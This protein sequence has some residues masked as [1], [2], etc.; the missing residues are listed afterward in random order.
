[1]EPVRLP[2]P[3][4]NELLH[5]AQ[6]SPEQE[7]CGLISGRDGAFHKCYPIANVAGDRKHLFALAPKGQ[8]DAMRR[9][10]AAGEE[11]VAIY[12]SHPDA[13]PLPSPADIQQSEY[14]NVL[15]LIISLNTEGV[16]ELRGFRIRGQKVEE[17]AIGI[18]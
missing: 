6:R 17:V 15:Y 10:R 12:H 16:L 9:M 4:V 7:I 11:L 14:S 1:M 13:P 18:C 2:R 5:L 8:I 3:L